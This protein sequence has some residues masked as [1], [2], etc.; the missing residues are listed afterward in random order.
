M[1]NGYRLYTLSYPYQGSIWALTI[2]A[3]SFEDAEARLKAMTWGK[4][5]GALSFTLP[6]W[7][8]WPWLADLIIWWKNRHE[9]DIG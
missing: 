4:V 5:D 7:A 6:G 1:T 8:C 3:Q 2:P 9:P